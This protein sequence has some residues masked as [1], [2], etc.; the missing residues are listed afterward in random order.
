MPIGLV[1]WVAIALLLFSLLF[2]WLQIECF[3]HCVGT[4][5]NKVHCH[6]ID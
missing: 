5:T 6:C 4:R 2:S 3:C 1:K